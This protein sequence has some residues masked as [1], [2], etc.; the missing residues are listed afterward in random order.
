MYDSPCLSMQVFKKPKNPVEVL[1]YDRCV[2]RVFVVYSALDH[3]GPGAGSSRKLLASL[4]LGFAGNNL[5]RR[6]AAK[7]LHSA[8]FGIFEPKNSPTLLHANNLSLR[9]IRLTLPLV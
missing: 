6:K 7:F 9:K 5:E 3:T 1:Y 2:A 8:A 4:Q